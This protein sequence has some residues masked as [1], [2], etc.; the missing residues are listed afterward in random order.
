MSYGKTYQLA[1]DGYI[2]DGWFVLRDYEKYFDKQ[3]LLQLLNSEYMQN[4]YERFS[5]GGIVQNISS[6]IV[7]KTVLPHT[8]LKEQKKIADCLTSIADRIIAETQKLNTLK[9]HKKGLMQQLFP[10]EGE[11]LPKLR[12]PEFQDSGEWEEKKLEDI[13]SFINRKVPL[14][15]VS[16]FNYIS[17]ENLLPDYGGVV[18]ASKLPPIGSATRFLKNDILISNIRPYLKK[19]WLADKDGAAS[20]DVIVIR[21]KAGVIHQYL[22]FLLKNDKFIDSVMEGAKGVKMPRGDISLMKQYPLALPPIP[23]Q[24]KIADCLTSI[25][26][27]IA[28]QSQAINLLKLHKKGLMQQLFPSVEEVNG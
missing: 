8:S 27:A 11:T 12:F 21:S 2:Y 17:T 7:Y 5:A 16:L 10:A 22:A 24:Q 25:D 3:F 26:E 14:E 13:S 6:D 4:Q 18:T 9:A 23:E 28:A 15:Q 20:N 1:I 19:V